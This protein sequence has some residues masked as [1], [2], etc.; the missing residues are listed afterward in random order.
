[1]ESSRGVRVEDVGVEER[2]RR[3]ERRVLILTALCCLLVVSL[4]LVTELHPRSVFASASESVLRVKGLVIEDTQG[5]ARIVLGAP[6]PA[7]SERQRKDETS[8]AMVFLDEQG[9]DRFLV[10]ETIAAQI[11][12]K[13]PEHFQRMG[14]S[15]SYGATIFDPAGNERGGM[16][17]LSNGG[18]V[19]RAVV[20]L[21]R[22][23][24]DAIGMMVDDKSGTA[25]LGVSYAPDVAKWSTGLWLGTQG[26]KAF[27][28]VKDVN[29]QPRATFGVGPELR[30]SFEVFDEKGKAERDLISG[31]GGSASK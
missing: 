3:L 25:A 22:P 6:F 23:G 29:D 7:T 12:G 30:P 1:M 28:T 18:T 11:D 21:D 27:V 17:F 2:V 4:A 8:T 26:K 13:V 19:S 20:A 15:S 5:R 24:A 16:G 10:G 14:R 31:G 9:H